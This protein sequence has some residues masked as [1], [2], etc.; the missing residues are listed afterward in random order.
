MWQIYLLFYIQVKRT[1][2]TESSQEEEDLQK[3]LRESL[4]E[5]SNGGPTCVNENDSF[6]DYEVIN[7]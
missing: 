5:N 6:D 3:A 2:K 7:I 4:K 1:V